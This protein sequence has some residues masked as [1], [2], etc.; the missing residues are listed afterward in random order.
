M[1]IIIIG[2]GG[3]S[4]VIQ[5][6]VFVSGKYEV[7]AVLDDKYHD[8]FQTRGIIH[9]PVSFLVKLLQEDIKLVIAIGDNLIRRKIVQQLALPKEAYAPL[10]HP[11]AIISPTS[12][13]GY[14]TVVMPNVVVNANSE[15][16]SHCIINT[17]AIVEHDNRIGDYTHLSP[18]VTLT[19]NVST[20]EG[21]HI[22]SSATIIPSKHLGSWS[23]IGAGSTVIEHIPAYTKAV[24]SPTR[25]IERINHKVIL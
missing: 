21:V 6:M 4:K 19:G 18:N 5:E 10:I 14:G 8:G 25:I 22:G 3:H 1:K 2:D 16:G 23:I 11:T 17:G 13:V 15:I 9:A 7:I 20:G 24:G 12:K